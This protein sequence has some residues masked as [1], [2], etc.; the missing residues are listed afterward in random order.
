MGRN[1]NEEQIALDFIEKKTGHK[2][3]DSTNEKITDGGRAFY[4]K[5]TGFVQVSFPLA[6]PFFFFSFFLLSC[7][8]GVGFYFACCIVLLFSPTSYPI[9]SGR[10][11]NTSC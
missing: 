2:L 1:A 4:E 8:I 3:S 7:Q 10:L 9:V 5:Q 6:G 11:V